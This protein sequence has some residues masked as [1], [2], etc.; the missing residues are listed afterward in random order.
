MRSRTPK[1]LH[2]LCGLPMV[3]WPVRA[4]L[5]AG[6]GRGRRRRLAR[7][8]AARCC[9]RKASSWPCSRSSRTAPAGA[10]RGAHRRAAIAA[11][12]TRTAPRWSCS[13]ATCRWCSAER[14]PSWWRAHDASGAAR[15]DGHARCSTIPSGYGRVVR[16]ARRRGRA[17]R[18]DQGRG[19]RHRE[20]ARD[21]GGQHRHL[22]VLRRTRC[23]A[24]LPRLSA[25][26]AQGELYLPQV[27]DLLRADGGSGRRARRRRRSGWCSASTTASALAAGARARAG[28][29]STS[30]TCSPGVTI[31]DPARHRDRR[32]RAD[33][34]GHDDRAVHARSAGATPHR[35]RELRRCGTPTSSTACSRTASASGPFA[36]L[37]PG[38]R[39]AR[40]LQGGD[41]RRDQELR[42]RRRRED[43]APL[44]H[45]RRRRRRATPTSAPARSP[46]TTTAAPSTARRSAAACAAAST[47]SFVAPGDGRRRRLHGAPARSITEDVPAG[48]A[49]RSR[50]RARPTSRATPSAQRAPRP[51]SRRGRTPSP[52][53]RDRR[54]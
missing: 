32:R 54:I 30:G 44:L 3:L 19:R 4:A 9:C 18:R 43:P 22:R 25:D 17:R 7:A 13:A 34:P 38:A 42:H 33:R 52:T 29:R 21:H 35:R 23:C 15:D 28:A 5:A 2:E 46:P 47:L 39:P 24:A 53:R 48:R 8:R 45:R 16:D 49:W 27:L 51:T 12:R 40:G 36:Y 41:V 31:V 20:R 11:A 37:R 26:N 10:V 14:S 1:V 6:A 50:A